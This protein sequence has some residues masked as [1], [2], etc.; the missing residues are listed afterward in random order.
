MTNTQSQHNTDQPIKRSKAARIAMGS[1]AAAAVGA[2]VYKAFTN[3]KATEYEVK[4]HEDGW[5]LIKNGS[6]R[7]SGVYHTKKEAVAAGR[8][9]AG[10][11][12]PSELKI[13]NSDGELGDSHSYERAES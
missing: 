8:D 2:V 13:Y 7:A 1:A 12:A 10:R 5:Q 4:P 9:L 11:K 3:G 6:H